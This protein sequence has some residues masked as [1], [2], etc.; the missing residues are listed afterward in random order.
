MTFPT[1]MGH[2]WTL[3]TTIPRPT[4]APWMARTRSSVLPART[5][6]FLS[7]EL[8]R[9]HLSTISIRGQLNR[10]DPAVFHDGG[11]VHFRRPD[12]PDY[13]GAEFPGPSIPAGRHLGDH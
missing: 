4:L 1:L 6:Y 9:P 7:A 8:R 2:S 12:V 3:A 13:R 5:A 11:N 10:D